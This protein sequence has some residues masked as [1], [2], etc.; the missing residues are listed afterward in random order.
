MTAYCTRTATHCNT[1]CNNILHQPTA[2]AHYDPLQHTSPH[3][4]H[5]NHDSVIF[6]LQHHGNSTLSLGGGHTH[7]Y[8]NT[9]THYNTHDW[10]IFTR[11][12]CEYVM[13]CINTPYP[14][15]TCALQHNA[16]TTTH[17]N[18]L[19]HTA[20]IPYLQGTWSHTATEYNTLQHH[21][22]SILQSGDIRTH[23]NT[24]QHT[25]THCNNTAAELYPRGTRA[26]TA[27]H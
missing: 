3:H 21:G 22:N 17:C 6:T 15:G 20:T 4:A 27:T 7:T 19:Q 9:H 1:H 10:V 18:T 13:S 11:V 23:C 8:T 12:T 5:N 14:R 24:L 16:H 2:T 25:A 26:H